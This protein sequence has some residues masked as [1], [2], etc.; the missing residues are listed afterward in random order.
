MRKTA[1]FTDD[2]HNGIQRHNAD[3]DLFQLYGVHYRIP[4]LFDQMQIVMEPT[5]NQLYNQIQLVMGPHYNQMQLLMR[6]PFNHVCD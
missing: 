1:L 5:Y 2:H 3:E 4:P 6:P